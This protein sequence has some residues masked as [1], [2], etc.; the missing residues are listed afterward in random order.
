MIN[1]PV[2]VSFDGR[3]FLAKSLSIT[4][5]IPDYP[6][7]DPEVNVE[8]ELHSDMVLPVETMIDNW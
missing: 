3:I 8:I 2:V 1:D 5:S 4:Q 6:S 7:S